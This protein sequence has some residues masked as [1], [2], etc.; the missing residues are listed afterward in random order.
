[1]SPVGLPGN[2][3]PGATREIVVPP[4]SDAKGPG[5]VAVPEEEEEDLVLE[6]R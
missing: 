2:R 5:E 1:M 3:L 4:Y 6:S